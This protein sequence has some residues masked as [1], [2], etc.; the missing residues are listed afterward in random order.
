MKAEQRPGNWAAYHACQWVRR[1]K[2]RHSTGARTGGK[3]ALHIKDHAWK[4]S[5]FRRPQKEA[6]RVETEWAADEDHQAGD[7]PPS[8]H[9]GRNPAADAELFQHEVTGKLEEEVSNNKE[10]P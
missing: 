8:N 10:A 6:Q 2:P 1:H 3:P 5:G 7:H 9:Q 4:E